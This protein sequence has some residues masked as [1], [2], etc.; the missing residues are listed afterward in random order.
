MIVIYDCPFFYL[1]VYYI[2]KKLLIMATKA[3]TVKK[4]DDP[5]WKG[6]HQLCTKIKGGKKVPD[7]VPE[8]KKKK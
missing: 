6:Y 1:I 8:A 3:K 5:C 2:Q 4:K 7:C